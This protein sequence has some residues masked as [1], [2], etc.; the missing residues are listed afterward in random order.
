MS[1]LGEVHYEV[2]DQSGRFVA[3]SNGDIYSMKKYQVYSDILNR[4]I[5]E[6]KSN[7][8]E[9]LKERLKV[10]IQNRV[11]NSNKKGFGKKSRNGDM[12]LAHTN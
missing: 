1:V 7:V 3:I 8:K 6:K 10:S 2:K 4:Y 5:K 9:S 12:K 11:R